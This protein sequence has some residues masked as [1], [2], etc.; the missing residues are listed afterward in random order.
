MIEYLRGTL[1]YREGMKVILD[2]NGVGYGL[3]VPAT[4]VLPALGS[5]LDLWVYT[6]VKE[7]VLAL[8]GF[9]SREMRLTFKILLDING[10]GPKLALAILSCLSL[11]DLHRLI[12]EKDIGLLCQVPGVGK[13]TAEKIFVELKSRAT[14]FPRSEEDLQIDQREKS[15]QAKALPFASMKSDLKSALQNFGFKDR[16]VQQVLQK[17][18]DQYCGEEFAELMRMAL[19]DLSKGSHAEARLDAL[20]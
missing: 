12:Q 5:P 18:S 3:D 17:L 20:F 1:L 13:K 2:V 15:S 8:Y 14:L 16:D 19:A 10:I 11:S 4:C 6:R 9:L 7:D